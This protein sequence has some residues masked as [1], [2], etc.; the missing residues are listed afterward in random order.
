MIMTSWSVI[1]SVNHHKK[2]RHHKSIIVN[3]RESSS[4][5]SSSPSKVE[6]FYGTDYSCEALADDLIQSWEGCGRREDLRLPEPNPVIATVS[7]SQPGVAGWRGRRVGGGN[8]GGGAAAGL[9]LLCT[10]AFF[11]LGRAAFVEMHWTVV[12]GGGG[13]ADGA[14]SVR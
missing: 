12:T 1:V 14:G 13:E 7:S 3:H 8:S 11:A 10:E 4:S 5:S 2:Y 9:H 6:P